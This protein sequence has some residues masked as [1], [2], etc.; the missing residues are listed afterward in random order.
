MALESSPGLPT[1]V[2]VSTF[3]S[4]PSRSD[5][6]YTPLIY[7]VGAKEGNPGRTKQ[8]F[9]DDCDINK[10]VERFTR[11]GMLPPPRG[12]QLY[13]D[14]SE[15]GSYHE[16]HLAIQHANDTFA[17]LPSHIRTRFHNDPG[18]FL[19]FLDNDENLEEARSLGLIP[20]L[21]QVEPD[22][23]STPVE[24]PPKEGETP[25]PVQGGD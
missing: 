19:K 7:D 14:F 18:A 5:R 25:S 20:P 11:T 2:S 10:I 21:D 22:E 3:T 1:S 23:P 24:T 13:G 8:E 4:L 6:R 15:V 17:E 16:A 9:V 12:V